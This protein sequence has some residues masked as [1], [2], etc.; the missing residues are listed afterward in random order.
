MVVR[1]A[2]RFGMGRHGGTGGDAPARANHWSAGLPGFEGAE[3]LASPGIAA[4]TASSFERP[5]GYNGMLLNSKSSAERAR[6]PR[7]R[8]PS[9]AAANAVA[10]HPRKR[11]GE[12]VHRASGSAVGGGMEA[13]DAGPSMYSRN[14]SGDRSPPAPP[15]RDTG[16]GSDVGWI[17][18]NYTSSPAFRLVWLCCP[19][20]FGDPK[21]RHPTDSAVVLAGS[22]TW[23]P[24][25]PVTPSR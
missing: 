1:A 23:E 10:E 21:G 5:R 25:I 17:N 3:S 13:R 18:L 6:G 8:A 11:S 15:L 2:T 7:V 9:P 14:R 22:P 16:I 24:K 20:P 12:P 4:S 19:S